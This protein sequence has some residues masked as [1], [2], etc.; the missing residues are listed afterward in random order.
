MEWTIGFAIAH[1][2]QQISGEIKNVWEFLESVN[3]VNNFRC[4]LLHGVVCG[5]SKS[6]AM[7][8][9]PRI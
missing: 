5:V 7:L 3:G 6:L 1:S 9:S 2:G 4:H 8:S